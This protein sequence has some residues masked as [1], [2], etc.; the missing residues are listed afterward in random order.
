MRVCLLVVLFM[1]LGAGRCGQMK[2][3]S[4]IKYLTQNNNN[5]NNITIKIMVHI[6]KALRRRLVKEYKIKTREKLKMITHRVL[7]EAKNY[8][9]HPSLNQ[10]V[11][12]VLLNTRFLKDVRNKISNEDARLYLKNYCDWQTKKK[13]AAKM[14]YYSVLLTG[15]DL[16]HIKNG[17]VL[18]TST[19]RSYTRGACQVKK[20]CALIEWDPKLVGFLIAHE[21]GHSLGMR[22]DGP[23]H[24]RCREENHIMAT[25]YDPLH[26]PK[27]WSSCSLNT[28]KQFLNM[29]H[30]SWCLKNE[31]ERGVTFKYIQ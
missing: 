1:C 25:R 27:T 26:H 10:T 15:M 19:G 13:V 11:N 2:S 22:H 16:F 30:L 5:N 23:P 8:F 28:L 17:K 18:R 3:T 21:I 6:D 31:N 24:N 14:L 20:S 7:T 4:T 12:F 9:K 29:N